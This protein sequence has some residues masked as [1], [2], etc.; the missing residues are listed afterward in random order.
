M[1]NKSVI[2][3]EAPDQDQAEENLKHQQCDNQTNLSNTNR[4]RLCLEN[5]ST[6]W[7]GV[8]FNLEFILKKYFIV[9]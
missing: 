5:R 4:W 9:K 7:T 8:S 1:L 3:E 6:G 2:F